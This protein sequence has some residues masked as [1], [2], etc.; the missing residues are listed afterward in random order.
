MDPTLVNRFGKNPSPWESRRA[1]LCSQSI[2]GKIRHDE[3]AEDSRRRAERLTLQRK[4][5]NRSGKELGYERNRNHK[6]RFD[7]STNRKF[8]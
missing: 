1:V 7:I 5:G 2:L 6:S 8:G 3:V 4:E